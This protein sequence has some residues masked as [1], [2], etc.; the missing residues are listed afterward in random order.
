MRDLRGLAVLS[1]V[2]VFMVLFMDAAAGEVEGRELM[3]DVRR[4]RGVGS[5]EDMA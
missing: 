5:G 1:L 4:V 2:L 3:R